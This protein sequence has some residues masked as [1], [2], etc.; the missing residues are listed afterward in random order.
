MHHKAKL[1]NLQVV[2]N[3]CRD[4]VQATCLQ[5]QRTTGETS[6]VTP[7]E[8]LRGCVSHV[9][10]P[11]GCKVTTR[12]GVLLGE[13]D[14]GKLRAA[15]R[16]H[17]DPKTGCHRLRDKE[18]ECVESECQCPSSALTSHQSK[19][20]VRGGVCL[21]R[22]TGRYICHISHLREDSPTYCQR[23]RKALE[24]LQLVWQTA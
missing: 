20:P 17:R 2:Q 8:R 6:H 13:E 16:C 19:Q 24:G 5:E 12:T 9:K 22:K 7:S 18:E 23:I 15:P 4:T 10:L 3:V 1:R 21:A 14:T 11:F